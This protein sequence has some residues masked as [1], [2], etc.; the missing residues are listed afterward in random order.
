NTDNKNF[1]LV[2]QSIFLSL[3]IIQTIIPWLGFIPL[4]VISLTIIHITVI[5]AAVVLGTKYGMIVGGF[6]GIS[7]IIKAYTMPIT[8]FDTLVFTNPIISVVP[9]I[10][11]GFTAGIVFH[12]IYSHYKSIIIGSI[13]SG[14]L[15]SLTNTIL[16]LGGMG[17]FYSQPTAEI[18]GVTSAVLLKTLMGIAITNGIPEAIAAGIITPIIAKT[19]FVATSIKPS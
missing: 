3:I 5:I 11:V 17:I 18:Y 10:L 9:R 2:L 8:P 6:W 14:V 16:V 12:L 13:L 19:L 15:G 7:T 4:G 1:Q